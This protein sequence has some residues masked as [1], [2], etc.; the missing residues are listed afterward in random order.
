MEHDESR[1]C[2]LAFV[3]AQQRE[4]ERER[5]G[6][7]HHLL[8][9]VL[10]RSAHGDYRL[11]ITSVSGILVTPSFITTYRSRWARLINPTFSPSV[12]EPHRPR[13]VDRA[14]GEGCVPLREMD[15]G[16]RYLFS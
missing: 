12:N 14:S 11:T 13:A 3:R 8:R 16:D 4:R 1:R 7:G 9:D 15:R 10:F 6:A 2:K 5:E